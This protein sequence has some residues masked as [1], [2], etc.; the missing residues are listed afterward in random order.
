[1]MQH[2]AQVLSTLE[3]STP[4]VCHCIRNVLE[5]LDRVHW[6]LLR[7]L[8]LTAEDAL[9]NHN[10][11][12][13][14]TRRDIGMLGVIH[15]TTLGLGPAQFQ[16]WFFPAER[17]VEPAHN[18]RRQGRLHSRQLYDWLT[19]DTELLRR[20]VLGLVRVYNDLP[21]VIVSQKTVKA[22][23]SLLQ[24]YVKD[25]VRKGQ[26]DWENAFNLRRKS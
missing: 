22:F 15:R 12:P 8:G 7:E 2:K 19:R 24:D 11:A 25:L 5:E 21:E 10:L 4:A 23:Q 6:R 17:R 1:M 20:S 3:F 14:Q 13:L 18:T 16:A 26:E 9:L